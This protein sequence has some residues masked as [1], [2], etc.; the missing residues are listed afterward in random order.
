MFNGIPMNTL[1]TPSEAKLWLQ[2]RG[3][4]IQAFALAHNVDAPTCYQILAGRKKGL[5]GKA[6][7]AAVALGIKP[8]SDD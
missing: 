7:D 5:R 4:S 1:R 2:D 3:I 8:P 6:H